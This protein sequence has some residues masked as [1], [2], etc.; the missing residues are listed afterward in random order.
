MAYVPVPEHLGPAPAR[1]PV[2]PRG[3]TGAVRDAARAVC[4]R[5]GGRTRG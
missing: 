2:T 3:G 5:G 1:P 4:R